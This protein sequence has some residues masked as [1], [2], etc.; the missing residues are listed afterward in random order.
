MSGRLRPR[1]IRFSNSFHTF[2]QYVLM[3]FKKSVYF[4]FA[5]V[6]LASCNGT[7]SPDSI[8]NGSEIIV[9]CT[10]KQW[11]GTVGETIRQALMQ[12]MPG[13]PDAE[14]QFTPVFIPEQNSGKFLLTNCNVLLVNI[15]PENKAGKI[16]TLTDV[17]SHPQ[18]VIKIKAGSDT[19]FTNLFSKNSELIN[20]LF[21]Q[22]ERARFDAQN[23]LNRNLVVEKMLEDEF[24]I[25]MIIP[26]DFYQAKKTSDFVWLR[27]DT[28]SMS[29]G[30]MIYI[31][32]YKDTAQ[33]NPA[34]VLASR[35]RYTQLYVPGPLKG[36][37]M[38]TAR[39]AYAP[40]PRKILF[41]NMFAIET[42]G[43]WKTEGDFM[44]GPFVNYTIVDAPRE[45]IIVF[46]GYV[47]YPN[48][49][50]R[51]YIRQLE[52]II[53]AAEFGEPGKKK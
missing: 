6:L 36:S 52:S 13:L 41:K 5:T 8:G 3:W 10:E 20:S 37:Y 39:E 40:V 31:Y 32:P 2:Q 7:I 38:T 9:I 34:A 47:Y 28:T 19:A 15:Q 51:N 50:K 24:G 48:N 42:R 18:Q 23:L 53:W 49:S 30:L 14:P 46:D 29:L 27:S 11:D 21:H 16:E 43:L 35:D 1:S 25:K 44:G 12:S 45:R 33:M 26:K 4:L 17:W 22:N